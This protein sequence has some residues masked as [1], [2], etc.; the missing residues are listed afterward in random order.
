MLCGVYIVRPAY[1]SLLHFFY[2]LACKY[3]SCEN[4][5]IP[6]LLE[7]NFITEINTYEKPVR[8]QFLSCFRF[9]MEI[10]TKTIVEARKR[11]FKD[12]T[13]TPIRQVFLV[14]VL[15]PTVDHFSACMKDIFWNADH[16]VKQG[17]RIYI[18]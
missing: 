8:P 11:F 7:R 9:P 2:S 14:D 13:Q 17:K 4:K 5:C 1:G 3:I 10:G 12:N 6:L 15:K 18:C 16:Y